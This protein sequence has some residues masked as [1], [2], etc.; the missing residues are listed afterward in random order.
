VL[1]GLRGEESIAELCRR[2]GIA[3]SMYYGWSILERPQ[4]AARRQH[5]ARRDFG[6]ALE[7]HPQQQTRL[8][9]GRY[10]C[11]VGRDGLTTA[12]DLGALCA[13]GGRTTNRQNPRER[14]R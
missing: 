3:S 2:E 7:D 8:G 9:T 11:N 6:L 1:E 12:L 10:Q 13:S 5:S 4:T 14:E